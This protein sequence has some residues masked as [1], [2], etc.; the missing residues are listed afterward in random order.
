MA[1]NQPNL[2]GR[3]LSPE[4]ERA[5][6]LYN[7]SPQDT[8]VGE[9][10]PSQLEPTPQETFESPL[11]AGE[12]TEEALSEGAL[13][14]RQDAP[15]ER[16]E[17]PDEDENTPLD[18][19]GDIALAPLR[20]VEGFVE[21][22]GGLFGSKWDRKDW[23][24]FGKSKTMVGTFGENIV[25]F[26]IGMIP[27]L[28][29]AGLIGKAAKVAKVAKVAKAAKA[30]KMAQLARGNR[31][32]DI[33]T[34]RKIAKAKKAA[35][36]SI[37]YGYAGAVSDFVAFKG[38]EERLSNLLQDVGVDNTFVD[39]L[40][41]NPE[42]DSSEMEGRLKN[43]IEGLF[44]GGVVGGTIG[45]VKYLSSIF[46]KFRRKN[47][48]V[49]KGMDEDDAID[50]A[51]G[52]ADADHTANPENAQGILGTNESILHETAVRENGAWPQPLR[53]GQ[54]LL[55]DGTG[56]RAGDELPMGTGS[57]APAPKKIPL[58]KLGGKMLERQTCPKPLKS[59]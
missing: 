10:G 53:V 55:D 22:V 11:L 6:R 28:G 15:Q 47:E 7:P 36:K 46:R 2:L 37:V 48:L 3:P 31:S 34:L 35:R 27:G 9:E 1:E 12:E 4:E 41:Y 23:S 38:Q 33:K 32:F 57:A 44:V 45:G 25:Q 16:Q 5:Q 50:I 20:G 18:F 42:Q 17:A 40:A 52:E 43:A 26:A 8:P 30:G 13:R 19:A 58:P 56:G 14:V 54:E 24:V 59:S 21:S 29:T 51:Q 39:Y 49:S